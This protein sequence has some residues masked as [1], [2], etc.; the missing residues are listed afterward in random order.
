MLLAGH[1]DFTAQSARDAS[2]SRLLPQVGCLEHASLLAFGLRQHHYQPRGV[3][4]RPGT[5]WLRRR[6]RALFRPSLKARAVSNGDLD[7]RR[8][9]IVLAISEEHIELGQTRYRFVSMRL[10]QAHNSGGK[11]QRLTTTSV[12]ALPAVTTR[13]EEQFGI[14]LVHR[15]TGRTHHRT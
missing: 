10:W 15:E 6:L 2:V 4:S 9:C 13:L 12:R 7:Y 14:D 1:F 3:A 5:D 11:G 8:T